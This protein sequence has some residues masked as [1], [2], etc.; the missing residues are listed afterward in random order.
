MATV[1]SPN[2]RIIHRSQLRSL[3]TPPLPK[4][5]VADPAMKPAAVLTD[6]S[7]VLSSPAPAPAAKVTVN[8][9]A[10]LNFTTPP[11]EVSAH[12]LPASTPPM[13][14]S[15]APARTGHLPVMS[16]A[17]SLANQDQVHVIDHPIA[18]HALALLRSKGTRAQDFRSAS[19]QLLY[20]LTIEALRSLP[21]RE[22]TVETGG[23]P[24]G[25]RILQRSA[26][27]L[28]VTRDGLGLA[29]NVADFV[30]N[31]QVGTISVESGLQSPDPTA[32]LHLANAPA[33]SDA[34]VLLF[35]PVVTTGL[36][37]LH[38][39]NTLRRSGAHDLALLSFTITSQALSRLHAAVPELSTWSAAIDGTWEE[40]RGALPGLG[41]FAA[42]MYE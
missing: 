42:R 28:A 41:S 25:G 38:A 21:T 2:G 27:F 36:S 4:V 15:N 31:L 11:I 1:I 34:R 17:K 6:E 32:R 39:A 22:V 8:G 24:I 30:P 18:Q 12:P 26:I 7:R 40:K 23:A 13:G 37:C 33:L 16:P 35:D 20:L 5:S 14:G 10:N 9:G 29:H 3:S 19:N